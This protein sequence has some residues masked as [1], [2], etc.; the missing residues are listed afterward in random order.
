ME[1][2]DSVVNEAEESA[3]AP[4]EADEVEEDTAGVVVGVSVVGVGVAV[5]GSGVAVVGV[6]VAVV[7]VGVEL[8]VDDEVVELESDETVTLNL[9]APVYESRP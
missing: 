2:D 6:G 7:G 9:S 1:A 3:S 8:V 4:V 5:V